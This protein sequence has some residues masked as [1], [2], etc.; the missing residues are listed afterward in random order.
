VYSNTIVTA[1]D[2]QKDFDYKKHL[3]LAEL[4]H[5]TH[6]ERGN[7]FIYFCR[8]TVTR[9]HDQKTKAITNSA[10]LDIGDRHMEGRIDDFYCGY[11]YYYIDVP[12][13]K[14]GTTERIIT[15]FP[16]NGATPYGND[17]RWGR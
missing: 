16:F 9:K 6:A 5:K 7:D 17:R 12:Y 10:E 3:E 13:D 2:E 14:D 4:L 11:E 1:G 8:I 15:S